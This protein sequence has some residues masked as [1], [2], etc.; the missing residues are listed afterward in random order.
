M[1]RRLILGK[2]LI[3]LGVLALLVCNTAA[4]LASGLARGLALAATAVLGAEVLGLNGFDMLH[5]DILH[6]F[7]LKY[8]TTLFASSQYKLS[9]LLKFPQ[10]RRRHSGNGLDKSFN[11]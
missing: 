1:L 7:Y 6:N 2:L 4:G 9:I 5:G 8:Y 3:C 10:L 11:E